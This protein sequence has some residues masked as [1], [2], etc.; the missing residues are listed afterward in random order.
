M[1]FTLPKMFFSLSRY[2]GLCNFPLSYPTFLRFQ[3]E[4]ENSIIIISD[5]SR[6]FLRI[7]SSAGDFGM[8]T[9]KD[10]I[11]IFEELYHPF[12]KIFLWTC[13]NVMGRCYILWKNVTLC[14][15]QLNL[16]MC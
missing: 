6:Y 5:V 8:E 12:Y 1:L 2:S 7:P 14:T 11:M 15:Y 3:D 16:V 9:Q 13:M 4:V 10:I